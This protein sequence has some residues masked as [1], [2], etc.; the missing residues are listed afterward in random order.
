MKRCNTECMVRV[1]VVS[2]SITSKTLCHDFNYYFA[3]SWPPQK[4]CGVRVAINYTT[5]N[6]STANFIL[7]STVLIWILKER[8]CNK[9]RGIENFY[10]EPVIGK[11]VKETHNW[12]GS[13][14]LFKSTAALS[15]YFIMVRMATSIRSVSMRREQQVCSMQF[16]YIMRMQW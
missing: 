11:F 2:C 9:L 6:D 4:L 14:H 5:L 1:P 7:G 8:H 15:I 10:F 3:F 13:S 12:S 16:S